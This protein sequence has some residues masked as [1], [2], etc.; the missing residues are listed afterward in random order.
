MLVERVIRDSPSEW[1]GGSVQDKPHTPGTHG[2]R[3]PLVTLPL[4]WAAG[5]YAVL[6]LKRLLRA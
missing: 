6:G 2:R 4:G 1:H 5:P 3:G